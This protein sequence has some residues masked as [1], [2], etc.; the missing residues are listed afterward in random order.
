MGPIFT[1]TLRVNIGLL[2]TDQYGIVS[3]DSRQRIKGIVEKPKPE[4][5]PSHLGV[6]GRY[7]LPGKIFKLLEQTQRG[8][9][10]EIQLTD[11]IAA[12]IKTEPVMAYCFSG[13]RYDCGSKLG[14]LKANVELAL[15]H[16]ELSEKWAQYI[17]ERFG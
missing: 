4:D 11:A 6:V 3:V 13:T 17:H 8:S 10:G 7:I 1:R 16:P 12:L 2:E 15:K 14:F 5:A 9:G